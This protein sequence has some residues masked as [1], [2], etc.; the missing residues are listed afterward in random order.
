M[1]TSEQIGELANALS[2]FQGEVENPKNTANNPFFKSKYAPLDVVINTTKKLLAKYGLSVI[3]FTLAEGDHIGVKSVLIHKSGQFI[4]GDTL[5]LKPEKVTPQG[6]GS[7]ITYARR[8][9]YSALLGISSEDDDDGNHAS[10]NNNAKTNAVYDNPP[11]GNTNTGKV[12]TSQEMATEAQLKKLF[13]ISKQKFPDD[14]TAKTYIYDTYNI[15][16]SKE[17]TKKQAIELIDILNK[18]ETINA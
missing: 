11:N 4:E 7:A 6:A 1:Q 12:K 8:Y 3:Q 2:Q 15:A 13:A 17:L 9:S 10:G 5:L 16:S 18:M 14:F